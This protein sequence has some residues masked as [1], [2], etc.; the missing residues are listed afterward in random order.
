MGD[1]KTL[2]QLD[3]EI[4]KIHWEGLKDDLMAAMEKRLGKI[5]MEVNGPVPG[6]SKR[7]IFSEQA[8]FEITIQFQ[9]RSLAEQVTAIALGGDDE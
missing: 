1:I 4:A 6:E 7:G 8:V 2:P 3:A 9:P 5:K